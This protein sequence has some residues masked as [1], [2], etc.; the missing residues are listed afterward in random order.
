MGLSP[1]GPVGIPGADAATLAA[2]PSPRLQEQ[3]QLYWA[4]DST[5]ELCKICAEGNKDVKIKPC[6]H[7]LCSRCLAAWQVGLPSP[8]SP[9]PSPRE[10]P[11]KDLPFAVWIRW[12]NGP[13]E[14][15]RLFRV[16]QE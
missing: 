6:G 8:L 1:R 2:S 5:F 13:R 7:L 14:S 4:M 9:L 12:E 16:T 11:L 15:R 3:L 10:K